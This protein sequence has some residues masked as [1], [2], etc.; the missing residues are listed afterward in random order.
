MKI[1][2]HQP[3]FLPWAG[4]ISKV[5]N[6]DVFVTYDIVQF[7][8]NNFQNRV[9][10]DNA[11]R[12]LSV[13]IN[14][15]L[16]NNPLICN[17]EILNER[18]LVK[19]AKTIQQTHAK[20][21]YKHRIQLILEYLQNPLWSKMLTDI[22]SDL[23]TLMLEELGVTREVVMA[24]V[25]QDDYPLTLSPQDRL[26][27]IVTDLGGTKYVVGS[28]YASYSKPEDYCV[29]LVVQDVAEDTYK[30]SFIDIMATVEDPL[31]YLADKIK[32]QETA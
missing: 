30:G 1:G 26:N 14:F 5:I 9:K 8:K 11:S 19:I 18:D 22:N 32:Y 29:P 28:G 3:S 31:A 17:L 12:W 15:S 10:F 21:P 13:P 25:P 16:K 6:S 23:L 7:E 20:S 2:V 24:K 4:F 27:K